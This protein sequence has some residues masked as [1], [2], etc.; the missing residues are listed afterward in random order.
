MKKIKVGIIGGAGYTGGE[1]LRI[2]INHPHTEI[3]FVHSNSNNGNKI[4]EVHTDLIGETDLVF[5]NHLSQEIDVLFLCVGHGDAKQFL[6]QNPFSESI[7]IIDLSQDFRLKANAENF[8]YGLV[9]MNR[10]KIKKA[11]YIANPGCF[12]TAIQLAL[13][14]LAKAN[15]LKNE[16]HI[17][18]ITGSTGAGQGLSTSSHF[19]WRNNNISVYK[20]FSHQHLIEIGESLVQLQADFNQEIDFIPQRGDFSRGIFASIYLKSDL[21]QEEAIELY[22]DYYKNHSFTFVSSK[23]IDLKQ[24]VNTNKCLLYIEKYRNKLAVFSVI[25]NL[26]KGASGQAVQNMNLL[27][28]LEETAGLKLKAIAF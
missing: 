15:Q 3:T 21:S 2:L 8:V 16:I 20:A 27:F 10:E 12:A 28:G 18:A 7:K 1:L 6:E 19:S 9:E 22:Q 25:D 17:N 5:T 14:P 11:N 26:L 13:L 23:N 4:Y 24:V